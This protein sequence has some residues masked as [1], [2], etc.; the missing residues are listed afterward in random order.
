MAWLRVVGTGARE[1]RGAGTCWGIKCCTI[2]FYINSLP[3]SPS[4]FTSPLPPNP[5]FSATAYLPAL[6]FPFVKLFQSDACLAFESI[7][8]FFLN[9]GASWLDTF[10][11]PPLPLLGAMERVLAKRDPGLVEALLAGQGGCQAPLWML[12]STLL[13]EVL[14]RPEWLKAFDHVVS[15]GPVYLPCLAI[16]Y[17]ETVR[18]RLVAAATGEDRAAFLR[19]CNAVDVNR[20]VKRAYDVM[21]GLREGE[22]EGVGRGVQVREGGGGGGGGGARVGGGQG[23]REGSV[24]DWALS[25]SHLPSP[26]PRLSTSPSAPHP[27][28]PT[29]P[30]PPHHHY[31]TYHHPHPSLHPIPTPICSPSPPGT[32]TPPSRPTPARPWTCI[33]GTAT[34]LRLRRKHCSVGGVWWQSLRSG[35]GGLRWRGRGGRRSGRDWRR[36]RRRGGGR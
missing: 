14:A 3:P 23:C 19:R 2:A 15:N 16:A 12:L 4:H 33:C 10:P 35:R 20:L 9:W 11:A 21:A 25:H 28:I 6:A 27:M 31:P 8:T 13:T 24:G 1:R 29:P 5:Q 36:L 17:A 7:A 34:A 30:H 32:P 26:S 22:M 18:D